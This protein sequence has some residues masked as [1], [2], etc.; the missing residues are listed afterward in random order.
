[1]SQRTPIDHTHHPLRDGAVFQLWRSLPPDHR[2]ILLARAEGR[3]GEVTL[4]MIADVRRELT[5][6]FGEEADTEPRRA[7]VGG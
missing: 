3:I 5:T 1:M 4:A 6:A 7:A 2:R